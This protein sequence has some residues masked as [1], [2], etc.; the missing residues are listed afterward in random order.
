MATA[1]LEEFKATLRL[2]WDDPSTDGERVFSYWNNQ[3]VTPSFCDREEVLHICRRSDGTFYLEIANLVHEGPLEELELILY[4][5]A[6]D[7]GW[8]G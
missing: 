5:W 3:R 1:S 8:L 4:R 2:T 6:E 7:E